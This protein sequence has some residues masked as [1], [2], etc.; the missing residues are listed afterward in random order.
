MNK[1]ELL[2]P[3]GSI[4]KLKTAIMYGADAVYMGVPDLSLRTQSKI[5][6]DE[7]VYAMEYAHS[8]G[9]RVYLTLNLFTHNEDIKKLP[10]F[11]ETIK[12]ARPDGVLIADPAVFS[13]VKK[14]AP[15]LNLHISTQANVCSYLSV[16]YWKEQGASL[17]VLARE[18]SIAE[19]SEIREKC[20]D[21]KLETFVHGSM[22]MSYSGRCLLSNFMTG[23]SSNRGNC[24]HSCRWNYKLHLQLKDNADIEITDQNKD[25]FNFLLEE[26]VR[27]GELMPIEETERGAYI[28]NSKDLCL[29]PKLDEYL[30]LGIDS[31]KVE[32]RNKNIYYLAIVARTYRKAIDDWY[33]NPDEW[34]YKNYI[35]DLWTVSNRGYTLGF[36]DGKITDYGHNY[37][38][39]K[40]LSEWEFAGF[41]EEI[42]KDFVIVHVKNRL[43]GGDKLEFITPK[44]IIKKSFDRFVNAKNDEAVTEIHSGQKPR[45]KISKYAFTADELSKLSE[46]VIIRKKSIPIGNAKNRIDKD[47]MDY[48]ASC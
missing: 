2:L 18:L 14:N 16:D 19:I 40:S 3:A 5:T 34:D 11:I 43:I 31:L 47:K 38:D 29:M 21:I 7:L 33:N 13:F 46:L 20:Q 39:N 9:K 22:C 10:K 24:S 36:Y 26:G 27:A 17:C 4:D 25:L 15:E 1:S 30:K 37:D 8:Y 6:E 45:I 35:D 48:I 42:T 12:K 28:L 44:H 41:I 32:G 23:R